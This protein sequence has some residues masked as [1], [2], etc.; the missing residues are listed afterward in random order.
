M[1]S[2]FIPNVAIY[3]YKLLSRAVFAASHKFWL[4]CF[5]F[6]ISNIWI[7][8]DSLLN[9]F[10]SSLFYCWDMQVPSDLFILCEF[11][12]WNTLQEYHITISQ[13]K[14]NRKIWK[15]KTQKPLPIFILISN[16]PLNLCFK[17]STLRA[18]NFP[19]WKYTLVRGSKSTYYPLCFLASRLGWHFKTLFIF[20]LLLPNLSIKILYQNTDSSNENR[21]ERMKMRNNEDIDL[22]EFGGKLNVLRGERMS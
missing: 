18:L 13:N 11:L 19:T 2:F 8:F 1:G 9:A 15:R 22:S 20:Q 12:L 17:T 10:I 7:P 21:K 5:C 6:W 14:F 4:L 3:C 16:W